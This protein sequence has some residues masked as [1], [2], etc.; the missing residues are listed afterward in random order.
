MLR[1]AIFGS[2]ALAA[3]SCNL[4]AGDS[5]VGKYVEVRTCQVYTGPCFA[6]GE[7]GSAGKQAIMTWR[8][9]RGSFAGV[10][11]KGTS[12]ALLVKASHTLGFNGFEDAEAKKAVIVVDQSAD[13]EQRAALKSFVLH[14]T[15]IAE[16]DVASVRSEQIDLNFDMKELTA[17]VEV[18][19]IAHIET[20]KA[21]KGDCICSN[22]SAYYPP[23]T[24]LFQFV[25]GVTIEGD[26]TARS[27]GSRWSVPDSRTAYLGVFNV[28]TAGTKLASRL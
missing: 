16:A 23:L 4:L 10:D 18:D 22:E 27:L 5:I 14:Q 7:V 13:A 19:N 8:V 20:R 24:E 9:D 21:R 28:E 11:L 1:A 6:N 17:T 2:L 12:A 15:G 26:V 25:P 3:F